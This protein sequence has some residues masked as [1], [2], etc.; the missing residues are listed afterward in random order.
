MRKNAIRLMIVTLL[1]CLMA[2]TLI[3]IRAAGGPSEITVWGWD[4]PDSVVQETFRKTHPSIKVNYVKMDWNSVIQKLLTTLVAGTGAPDVANIECEAVAQF[5]ARA[6][7]GGMVD[8]SKQ[9]A[10]YKKDIAPYSLSIGTAPNGKIIALPYDAAPAIV[11]YRRDAF[12]KAGIKGEEI[13]SWADLIEAGKKMGA[14]SGGKIKLCATPSE[15]FNFQFLLN[16]GKGGLID[17]NGRL[18]LVTRRKEALAALKMARAAVDAGVVAQVAGWGNDWYAGFKNGNIATY[19]SGCWLG[20]G[21]KV[22]L[23]PETKGKWGAMPLPQ[24]KQG[25]QGGTWGCIPEQSKNREAAWEYLRWNSLDVNG[26]AKL[27]FIN[28]TWQTIPAYR[29]CYEDPIFHQADEFFGG[30]KVGEL[31]IETTAKAPKMFF[32]EKDREA[33][34]LMHAEFA[35]CLVEKSISPEQALDNAVKAIMGRGLAKK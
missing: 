33:I 26:G 34:A 11:F 22:D 8:L 1:I 4:N 21:I 10:K 18:A 7:N 19:T 28:S 32:H 2:A 9:V 3:P 13:K 30:Q 14:A 17:K 20:G 15:L 12:E 5:M 29:P 25:F 24:A 16:D 6:Q 35:K 31:F 23:A 27:G